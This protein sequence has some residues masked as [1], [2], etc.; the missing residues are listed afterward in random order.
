M[1]I[2]YVPL[3]TFVSTLL[4]QIIIIFILEKRKRKKINKMSA[5]EEYK[6]NMKLIMKILIALVIS[7]ILS[8]AS[9]FGRGIY[10][11]FELRKNH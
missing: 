9:F 2:Y 11:L 5:E 1:N 4:F 10:V 7:M 6:I 8:I 3:I